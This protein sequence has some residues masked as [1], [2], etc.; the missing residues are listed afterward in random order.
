MKSERK[1]RSDRVDATSSPNRPPSASRRRIASQARRA[2]A[3][4]APPWRSRSDRPR[5]ASPAAAAQ[6]SQYSWRLRMDA[7]SA[8][9]GW[10][11]QKPWAIDLAFFTPTCKAAFL[12]DVNVDPALQRSGIGRRLLER[13]T[14]AA[15]EWPVEA[16]R[17]DT[18]DGA[19]ARRTVLESADSRTSVTR[20]IAE[21]HSSISIS[22]SGA[23]Y[24]TLA[25]VPEVTASMS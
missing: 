20:S 21:C 5:G 13:A 16:I 18:Y 23:A 1:H 15:K 12:H 17:V 14:T 4:A 9:C 8:R 10:K 25:R 3:P 7:S 11:R 6:T 19:A 2:T 24:S 22:F